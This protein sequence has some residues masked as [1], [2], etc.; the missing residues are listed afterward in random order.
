MTEQ[1]TPNAESSPAVR[2]DNLY[3]LVLADGLKLESGGK[4]ILYKVVSLRDTNVAD[5]R[6]AEALSERA[7]MV[8]GGWKLLVSDSNFKHVL[9]MLHIESFHCDDTV[10]PRGLIDLDMY[11]RLSSRDLEL[12]EQRIFLADTGQRSA[13]RQHHAG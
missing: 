6:K 5:E 4:D 3:K 13:V 1:S 10:I 7:M 2:I 12:I 11:D 8:G 9:N